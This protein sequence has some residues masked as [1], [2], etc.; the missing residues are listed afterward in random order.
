[1]SATYRE[2]GLVVVAVNLDED[3]DDAERFLSGRPGDFEHVR[4]PG[5]TLAERFGVTVMPSAILFDRDG[6]PAFR[7]EGFHLRKVGEYERHI[8]D[9]LEGR[10]PR[11]ALDLDPGKRR[12]GGVRPWER[13]VLALPEMQ[14]IADPL[15]IE[16]DDHVYFSKEASSGGRGFGGGGCGCN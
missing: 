8:V 11:T 6:R 14:L 15:E 12:G 7:H 16:F 13:G 3:G 2:R 9:L 5:G 10:G 1:M 4:D